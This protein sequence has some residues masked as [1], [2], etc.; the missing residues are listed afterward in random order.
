MKLISTLSLSALIGAVMGLSSPAQAEFPERPVEF[1]VPAAAGQGSD[2]LVRTIAAKL[3]EKWGEPVVV[4][5][6]TGANGSIAEAYVASAAPDGH[7][8]LSIGPSRTI[9]T[10]SPDPAAAYDQVNGL[11]PVTQMIRQP[12]VIFANT[13]MSANTLPELVEMA[14]ADP[15]SINYGSNGPDGPM[16]LS[17]RAFMGVT[18]T[19]FVGIAYKSAGDML[20][21]LLSGDVSVS[22]ASMGFSSQH[23]RAG[24]VKALAVADAERSPLF[25]DVPTVAEAMG[26]DRF[27]INHWQGAFVTAGTPDDVVAKIN[28]DLTAV[29]NDPEVNKLLAAEGFQVVGNTAAEFAE[30]IKEETSV[31][32]SA[33]AINATTN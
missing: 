16:D 28:A 11:I 20:L 18:G 15:R 23:I 24:K 3:Q 7:T 14:K 26:M 22:V 4:V 33:M 1:V 5:N 29:L 12:M 30:I 17:M 13:G 10:A 8:L 2:I 9:F 31:W 25:P 32:T 27:V 6:K 19:E 21:G